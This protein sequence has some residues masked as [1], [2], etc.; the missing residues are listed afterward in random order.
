[1]EV[2]REP[3]SVPELAAQPVFAGAVEENNSSSAA[4]SG[5]GHASTTDQITAAPLDGIE[6]R[7]REL[8]NRL[9]EILRQAEPLIATHQP[10][11]LLNRCGYQLADVL[12]TNQFDL[13]RLL[14]GSEG[15]LALITEATLATQPLPRYRGVALLLFDR[16]ESAALGRR[17]NPAV[18]W[19]CACDL[20][21]RRHL[22]LARETAAEYEALVPADA[23]AVLLVEHSGDDSAAVRDRLAANGRSSPPQKTI[24]VRFPAG[25]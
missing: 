20:L 13:P 23:E 12:G 14:C 10:R 7:R 4:L 19:P 21:D 16:L 17:R 2:G 5:N 9:T 3:V 15:T 18:R 22:S 25:F 6:G 1:M 24:G 11:S 8:V